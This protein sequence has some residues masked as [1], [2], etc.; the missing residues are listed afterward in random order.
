LPTNDEAAV[1]QEDGAVQESS[2]PVTTLALAPSSYTQQST[3]GSSWLSQIVQS[4]RQLNPWIFVLLGVA[5][6]GLGIRYYLTAL[7]RTELASTPVP[8]VAVSSDAVMA[9]G[10]IEPKGETIKLSVANAQDSRVNQLLVEEGDRVQ[11]GQVIAIL[12]GLDKKKVGVAQA[13]QNVEIARA[14]L[15]KAQAG[16]GKTG[17]IAAQ[18]SQ[19]ARLEAQLGTE[20]AEKQAAVVQAESQLRYAKTL[21]QRYQMLYQSGAA[22][23]AELERKQGDVETAQAQLA[24]ANAQLNNV[25][26]TLQQ[27]IQ[28]ARALLSNL[29]EVRPVD[30]NVAQ[31]ELKYALTQV[32]QAQAELQDL[33]VRVP[34]AGQI[35]KINTRVG[36]QVNVSQGIAELGQTDQMYAIAEVYETDVGKIQRG[37]R[38]TIVSENGGFTGEIYGTVDRIG[39]QIKKKDILDSDPAAEKDARVVEVKV[40][41]RP[42]DTPKVAG[43]TNLQVRV[44]IDLTGS[45]P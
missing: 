22:S 26:S 14:K 33:Y 34:I 11:A 1:G 38:A 21:Y 6:F 13:R 18:Q 15:A 7:N 42:E 27:E 2:T 4:W 9:L 31:A 16:D 29:S 35:L 41:L 3:S 5:C 19:I 45:H 28:R 43:L 8:P 24:M 44:R 20:K 10:R 40:R 23:R 25:T 12:Q 36:E 32:D 17:E 37:Q 30:M 39:S